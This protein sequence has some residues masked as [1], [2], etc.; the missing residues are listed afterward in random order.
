MLTRSQAYTLVGLLVDDTLSMVIGLRLCIGAYRVYYALCRSVGLEKDA[1]AVEVLSECY[2]LGRFDWSS[3]VYYLD[4]YL[5]FKDHIEKIKM[6]EALGL[7]LPFLK[8]RLKPTQLID[9]TEHGC[10]YCTCRID[11]EISVLSSVTGVV[12]W[13]HWYWENDPDRFQ[14][15]KRDD[16]ILVKRRAD[17]KA[18]MQAL[19]VMRERRKRAGETRAKIRSKAQKGMQENPQGQT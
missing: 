11:E 8:Q 19:K 16:S 15:P 5:F 9:K 17:I 2:R 18:Y 1:P 6:A 4:R 13:T 3:L 7:G 14:R 10:K 12:N